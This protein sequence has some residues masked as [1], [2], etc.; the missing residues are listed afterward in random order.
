MNKLVTTLV[1]LLTVISSA[2][3]YASVDSVSLASYCKLVPM[4]D[5]QKYRIV[6]QAPQIEDV[7]VLLYDDK[8]QLVF[9]EVVE[10]TD[11]FAKIYDLSAIREGG[12]TFELK[13]KSFSYTE[14]ITLETWDA[15]GIV[16]SAVD[17]KKVALLGNTDEAFSLS[18]VDERGQVVFE[19]DFKKDQMVKKLYNLQKVDGKTAS[20]VLYKGSKVVRQTVV[21]L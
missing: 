5:A 14:K 1:L 9:S 13:S 15:E 12:Y 11:G 2:Y 7:K 21:K 16:I 3:T 6:Y 19:D 18:I 17:G 10:D 8:N 4:A 20:F